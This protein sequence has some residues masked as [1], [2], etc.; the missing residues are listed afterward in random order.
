MRVIFLSFLF[1]LNS[2][3]AHN[4]YEKINFSS[5]DSA[6]L[7]ESLRNLIRDT[8]RPRSYGALFNEFSESD[9]D[10][11]YDNDGTIVDIYS[12]N[13]KRPDFYCYKST[14]KKCGQY[15]KESDCYN[16]EHLFPQSAFQ[17][18]HP[19]KSDF[20]HIYPTDGLVNNKRGSHP[21]G[22]VGKTLWTSQNGSKLG[23]SI[24]SKVNSL[25]FEPIDEF[26]GDI[27]R[28]LFYFALRYQAKHSGFNHRMLSSSKISFYKE[29]ILKT[30]YSWHLQDPVSD[31]EKNRNEKGFSFQKNRNPFIDF[32]K[33]VKKFWRP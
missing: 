19:M 18:R 7:K 16:R 29:S 28:A 22:K 32:P 8:H 9:I 10:I 26:K 27:A 2:Y 25:V 21:F 24:D 12:E 6:S 5:L 33:L 4:Y 15:K 30:L 31:H 1:C 13:P 14:K 17:Q 11:F 3:A 23:Y 20:F